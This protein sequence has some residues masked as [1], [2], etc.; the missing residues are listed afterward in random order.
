M[1]TPS[2][3]S[4][5]ADDNKILEEGEKR[6]EDTS[7]MEEGRVM[8]NDCKETDTSEAGPVAPTSGH[9]EEEEKIDSEREEGEIVEDGDVNE[10]VRPSAS[11]RSTAPPQLVLVPSPSRIHGDEPLTQ[12]GSIGTPVKSSSPSTRLTE[13]PPVSFPP[14]LSSEPQT[15]RSGESPSVAM[16]TDPPP[17]SEVGRVSGQAPPL[18]DQESSDD[19]DEEAIDLEIVIEGEEDDE[20]VVVMERPS[21]IKTQPA[22]GSVTM[23]TTDSASS[24]GEG[25]GEGGKRSKEC[26]KVKQFFTTLQRFANNISHD[27]AE[28]VQELITALVVSTG[29]VHVHVRVRVIITCNYM[30]RMRMII[31][32]HVHVH[33]VF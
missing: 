18:S 10:T 1:T 21:S 13:S 3:Y 2:S 31:I 24:G 9:F 11:D 17:V 25:R 23:E 8:T 26:A 12:E 6:E 32:I 27:V 7:I 29:T 22:G 16:E 19:S 15:H 14:T 33:Q 20:D 5:T 30:Y 28:Q 4:P